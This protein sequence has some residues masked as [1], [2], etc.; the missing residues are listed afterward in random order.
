VRAEGAAVVH[1]LVDA[2]RR[3]NRVDVVSHVTAAVAAH[4]RAELRP[5][6][7]GRGR[8]VA[9]EVLQERT[10]DRR[11]SAGAAVVD[12]EHVAPVE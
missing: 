10:V 5:A 9:G 8:N 3:A 12:H 6:G 11:G 1:D 4:R 7:A 2:K